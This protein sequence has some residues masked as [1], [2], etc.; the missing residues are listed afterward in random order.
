MK[1]QYKNSIRFTTKLRIKKLNIFEIHN[2]NIDSAKN[3][4]FNNKIF[5]YHK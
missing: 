4:N 2:K 5:C 1:V 3:N